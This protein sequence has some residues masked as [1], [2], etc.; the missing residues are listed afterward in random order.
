M[1]F[2]GGMLFS[3]FVGDSPSNSG[4]CRA[5][6]SVRAFDA[7]PPLARKIC[8]VSCGRGALSLRA[9]AT[10]LAAFS[11][12]AAISLPHRCSPE[13]RVMASVPC[14]PYPHAFSLSRIGQ[15]SPSPWPRAAANPFPR[16]KAGGSLCPGHR[17]LRPLHR[18]PPALLPRHPRRQPRASMSCKMYDLSGVADALTLLVPA[19]PSPVSA[20]PRGFLRVSTASSLFRCEYH[21]ARLHIA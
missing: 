11:P 13:S 12:A 1:N 8:L 7:L 10:L 21:A 4:A 18:L 2:T 9:S 14:A 15:V 17:S 20:I 19:S 5:S 16:C 3:E 6:A